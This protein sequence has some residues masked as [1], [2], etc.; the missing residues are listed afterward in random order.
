DRHPAGAGDPCRRRHRRPRRHRGPARRRRAVLPALPRRARGR[1]ARAPDRGLPAR[2]DA[3]GAG[4]GGA[5]RAAACAPGPGGPAP[6]G[7]R[8]PDRGLP[9]RAD[10]VGGGGAGAPRAAAGAPGPGGRGPGGA[11]MSAAGREARPAGPPGAGAVDWAAV[12][13]DFPLLGR[14]VHG[15]PLV[16]LDSANT[17]Q[18]PALVIEAVDAFY[19]RHHAN[20]SREA[21]QLG[22]EATDA[23]EGAR[24]RLARFINV[25]ADELVLTSGTTFAI[26]LDAYSWA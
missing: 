21:P 26:N 19:R 16:Y 9:A 22:T 15:K 23:Y 7:A 24:A 6:R 13:A 4:G 20:A 17:G 1:G 10:A 8:G 14:E 11:R 25:R 18:K 12:R 5:P 3:V 2:A